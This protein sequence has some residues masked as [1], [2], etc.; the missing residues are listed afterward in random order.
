MILFYSYLLCAPSYVRSYAIKY[1]K[2]IRITLQTVFCLFVR[3]WW[4][5]HA[6]RLLRSTKANVFPSTSACSFQQNTQIM[7]SIN[8]SQPRLRL[9]VMPN[10]IFCSEFRC[11]LATG[12]RHPL[13][14][15]P[16]RQQWLNLIVAVNRRFRHQFDQ[17]LLLFFRRVRGISGRWVL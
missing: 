9:D 2:E 1:E 4:C 10:M 3:C 16:P 11:V 8:I 7:R 14:P 6:L 17:N 12:R 5:C 15:R 13:C